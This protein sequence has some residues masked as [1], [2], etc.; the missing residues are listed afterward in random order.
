M[1]ITKEEKKEI[2]E[3]HK[4]LWEG[5]LRF[6][7]LLYDEH[8]EGLYEFLKNNRVEPIASIKCIVF[9]SMGFPPSIRKS[10]FFCNE[11]YDPRNFCSDKCPVMV[12]IGISCYDNDSLYHEIN[13]AILHKEEIKKIRKLIEKAIKV[14]I[15]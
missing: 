8:V 6:I 7:E 10:C 14:K 9:T 12:S 13:S 11:F 4:K 3:N 2:N 5:I 15:K 1:K